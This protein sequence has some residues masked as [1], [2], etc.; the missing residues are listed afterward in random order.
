MQE[1]NP[2]AK[3]PSGW[4][5]S[6][7]VAGTLALTLCA[8]GT[9][10]AASVVPA[11]ANVPASNDYTIGTPSS[12]V[13]GVTATPATVTS[14]TTLQDFQVKFTATTALVST[15]TITIGDSDAEGVTS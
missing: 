11:S 3:T 5:R 7:L 4:R 8:L 6:K 14:G 10:L 2:S 9:G 1:S 12:A 15:D 13:T